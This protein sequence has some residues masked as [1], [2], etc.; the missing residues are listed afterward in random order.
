MKLQSKVHEPDDTNMISLI[1]IV[2][3]I[4][5][6][7]LI[8]SIIRPFSAKDIELV[9]SLSKD[10]YT[11]HAQTL[12][13]DKTG[14]LI[15]NGTPTDPQDLLTMLGKGMVIPEGEQG[16]ARLNIIADQSL[17]SGILLDHLKTIQS[18]KFASI[19]LVTERKKQ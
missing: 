14:N 18:L 3:L 15:I 17:P 11:R 8:A 2:F 9:K 10:K 13:I 19:K 6:F 12:V 1:N 5:I 4:L 16:E 7:F